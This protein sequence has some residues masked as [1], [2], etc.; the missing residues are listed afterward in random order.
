MRTRLVIAASIGIAAMLLLAGCTDE[1]GG[2]E[3][4]I[5]GSPTSESQE[6]GHGLPNSGAPKVEKPIDTGQFEADPCSVASTGQLRKAGF[7]VKSAESEPEGTT[8]SECIWKFERG[9][10]GARYGS[11]AGAFIGLHDQGLSAL[12]ARRSSYKLFEELPSVAGYPAVIYNTTDARKQGLCTVSIGIRDDQ[13]YEIATSL[14]T[15]HPDY[16]DSC[17][18]A[19]EIAEIAVE[20]MKKGQP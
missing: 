15:G 3:G 13:N 12:Y 5:G 20:M 19:V 8:G 18:V 16:A 7:T 2:T 10:G 14:D 1:R 17:K 9:P 11:L 4:P 6:S